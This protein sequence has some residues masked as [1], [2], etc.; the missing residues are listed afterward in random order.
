MEQQD[1]SKKQRKIAI[2]VLGVIVPVVTIAGFFAV[3]KM[4]AMM[5]QP[6]ETAPQEQFTGEAGP[7][8]QVQTDCQQSAEKIAKATDMNTVVAEYKQNAGNCREVYFVIKGNT[9]FRNEGMYPDLVVDI[10]TQLYKNDKPKAIE[11]LQFA[12]SISAWD[13]N[14]GP[15][16]CE[17]GIVLDS[18]LESMNLPE[19]KLCIKLSD[20]KEKLLPGLKA[21][22]F[23]SLSKMLPNDKVVWLGLPDSDVGCPEKISAIIKLVQNSTA[24]GVTLD[25]ARPENA[26]SSSLSFMYKSKTEDKVILDFSTAGECLQLR[27]VLV[28]GPQ[29][30]E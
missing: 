17:S 23:E 4:R 30:N 24:G 12:K 11:I 9:K 15:T 3:I 25:E 28:P 29:A 8:T 6:T 20:Y 14:M 10:A 16:V 5:S 27:S 7:S 22:N 21:K 13:F 2:L 19:E 18:Y 1:E 26:E